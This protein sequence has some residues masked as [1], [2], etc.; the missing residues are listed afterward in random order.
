MAPIGKSYRPPP[1]GR[2]GA[3]GRCP[4]AG[5]GRVVGAGH[6]DVRGLCSPCR[7]Y[8][9]PSA[10]P[11]TLPGHCDR[12]VRV[13]RPARCATTGVR[14]R[15]AMRRRARMF[16]SDR[17][18]AATPVFRPAA[19]RRLSPLRV[20]LRA[21]PLPMR[22]HRHPGPRRRN[23]RRRA[24]RR[25]NEPCR[26]ARTRMSPPSP[27]PNPYPRTA[28]KENADCRN[29]HVA[30]ALA[31]IGIGGHL[32]MPPLPHHRAYGSVPRRFDRIRPQ[33]G[34]RVWGGRA[35]RN[36][37]CVGPAGPPHVR[38][39]ASTPSASQRRWRLGPLRV[40]GGGAP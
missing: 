4:G 17:A 40:P 5:A 6:L 33:Q 25:G 11:C 19:R 20:I 21:V 34:C 18:V 2:R 32:T 15:S 1:P 8:P 13:G 27:A 12:T 10:G 9:P 36:G 26:T 39:C 14:R 38:P 29:F 31:G 23:R 24:R 30:S 16:C 3:C 35:S 37:G 22:H 28:G 7:R